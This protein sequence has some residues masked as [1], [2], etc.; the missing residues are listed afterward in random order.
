MRV[1][2]VLM[3]RVLMPL[4]MVIFSL[5]AI[6]ASAACMQGAF[7]NVETLSPNDRGK[8][9]DV[10]VA[11]EDVEAFRQYGLEVRECPPKLLSPGG[12]AAER[13]AICVATYSGNEAVQAQLARVFGIHPGILCESA[14]KLAGEWQGKKIG[15]QDGRPPWLD[16]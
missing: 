11:E 3:R 2:G 6:P 5:I 16:E 7:Q 10:V 14:E 1:S 4:S 13:D 15:W 12:Q 8:S 9:Y